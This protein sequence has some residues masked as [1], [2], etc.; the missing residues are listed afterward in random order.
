MVHEASL[1]SL[2]PVVLTHLSFALGAVALGPAALFARKGSPL[3]RASGYV[4]VV[5]MLGTAVSA[6]FIR[7]TSG[8]QVGGFSPIH[9]LI[10]VTVGGVGTAMWHVFRRNIAAHRK[11]MQQTYIGACLIAGAFTLLPGRYLGDLLWHHALGL[12]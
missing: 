4:W 10:V 5:L 12:V 3:H 11:A 1:S 9:L 7:R 6:F 2:S 8:F